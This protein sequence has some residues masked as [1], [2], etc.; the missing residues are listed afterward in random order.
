MWRLKIAKGGPWLKSGNSHIGRETW[1]FDQ[2]FGSKEEREA[3]DSAREEFKKNRFQMRH[4]SDILAR[5][6]VTCWIMVVAQ[7]SYGIVSDPHI[8]YE[9]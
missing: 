1:E 7:N 2:D 3:V 9:T 8:I 4:S 6:Q 5:M